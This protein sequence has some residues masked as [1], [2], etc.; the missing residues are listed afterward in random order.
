M[1]IGGRRLKRAELVNTPW[2]ERFPTTD[3]LAAIKPGSVIAYADY[4][5]VG[6]T[7][8]QWFTVTRVNGACLEGVQHGACLELDGS[9]S[10]FANLGLTCIA[11]YDEIIQVRRDEK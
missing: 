11:K 2:A 7:F 6:R 4:S 9:Q 3:D 8:I 5:S 10:P 1:Q